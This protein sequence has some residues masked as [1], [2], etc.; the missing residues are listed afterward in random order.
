MEAEVLDECLKVQTPQ[1]TKHVFEQ[2]QQ[3]VIAPAWWTSGLSDLQWSG[4]HYVGDG[5]LSDPTFA[6]N[7]LRHYLS[8]AFKE[9]ESGNT[10]P[11][12]GYLAMNGLL[13]PLTTVFNATTALKLA[14][15]SDEFASYKTKE[16]TWEHVISTALPTKR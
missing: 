1:W 3:R 4:V 7:Y 16:E 5:E 8:Y 10:K 13:E 14:E 12:E 11:I 9:K 2:M 6:H 15:R